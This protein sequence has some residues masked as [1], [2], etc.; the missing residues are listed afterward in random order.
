MPLPL[1][2]EHS[3]TFSA[4]LPAV[5]LAVQRYADAM[6][7]ADHGVLGRFLGT[8]PRSGFALAEEIERE[9]VVLAGQHRF[10][11]YRLVFEL[12]QESEIAT[13][14]S[15]RSLAAFPG[16]RGRIY[17]TL[18]MGTRGHLIAVRHMLRTIR[19]QVG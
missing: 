6:T 8:V 17:R 11:R 1:L 4:P 18:L 3:A 15:I 16:A 5:W 10:A 12:D 14:L 19:R 13:R 7:R 9:R 2:D